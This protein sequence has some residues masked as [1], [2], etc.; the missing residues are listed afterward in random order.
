MTG[1]GSCTVALGPHA[2]AVRRE[3]GPI[4]WS[5]LEVAVAASHATATGAVAMISVRTLADTL[6]V[7]KDTAARAVLVLR[8]A[9]LVSPIQP[10]T[11]AGAFAR[12]SY[13]L[14]VPADVLSCGRVARVHARAR[15]I[16]PC[17]V[18]QLALLPE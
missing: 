1:P 10:R 11:R 6:A 18:E 2:D 16:A 8:R 17:S 14:H 12:G 9:G 7:S 13:Q 15:V 3:V 5:C 4:A